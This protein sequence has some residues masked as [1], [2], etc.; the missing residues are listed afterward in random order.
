MET[1]LPRRADDLPEAFAR[2]F[3]TGNPAAVLSLYPEGSVLV[4][5]PGEPRSGPGVA[6]G[7]AEHLALGLPIEVHPRHIY[8]SGD[9]ALLV[10]DWRIEGTATD[11]RQVRFSGTATDVARCGSD[12]YW[13]YAIDNP[14]GTA[15]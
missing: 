12:G 8:R 9:V 13:R 4:V 15:G 3:N 7:L 10:V 6:A 5:G 2:R 14:M 1:A 11:G